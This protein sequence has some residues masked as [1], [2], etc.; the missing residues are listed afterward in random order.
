MH[1]LMILSN[2]FTHDPRVYNEAKSLIKVGHEA[3]VLARDR[4]N[5]NPPREVRDGMLIRRIYNTRFISMLPYNVF[6]LYFWWNKGYDDAL[7]L[8]KEKPFDVI[9]C[10]DLAILPIGVKLKKKYG[11]PLIYDAYDLWGYMIMVDLPK[12][13]ANY[14]FWKEKRFIR[15]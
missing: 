14:Y 4:Q 10:N 8:Y 7:K 12:W 5:E 13:W 3:T 1:I 6:D 15:R 2:P 11:S 9:H